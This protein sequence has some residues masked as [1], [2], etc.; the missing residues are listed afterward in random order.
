MLSVAAAEP[1]VMTGIPLLVTVANSSANETKTVAYRPGPL[2]FPPDMQGASVHALSLD[3]EV[4]DDACFS[5][6][7]D[8]PDL[9]DKIVLVRIS[10]QCTDMEQVA[11]IRPYQPL[12]ILFYH[13]PETMFFNPWSDSFAGP[14]G[15]II[16]EAG[17]YIV[18]A[19]TNGEI[20]TLDFSQ[21]DSKWV[22]MAYSGHAGTPSP[23][24]G[25]GA[26]WDLQIKP[27]IAAPGAYITAPFLTS[28]S[29]WR[30]MSGTFSSAPYVAGVAAL[31]ISK[32]G[33]RSQHGKGF[34]KMLHAR[35]TSSG[36]AMPWINTMTG[37]TGGS[38]LSSPM[39]V[40]TGLLDARKVMNYTTQLSLT[41]F[42]LNDTHHFSRYHSVD[43]TNN[44]DKEV[45]YTFAVQD[46]GGFDAFETDRSIIDKAP[47]MR[48]IDAI[49]MYKLKPEV[50]FPSG[51]FRVKAGETRKAE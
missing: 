24:T 21:V 33:G 10:L 32:H 18:N 46:A 20:V 5:L 36:S 2:A 19:I 9:T 41:R 30:A 13:N 12:G 23:F 34:A 51:T 49:S 47:T 3:P 6:P 8:T 16:P 31:Y 29:M 14:M 42:N 15:I 45:V 1:N 7:H 44:G 50:R 35:I 4:K 25:W 37:D 26:T 11:N 43:I 39:Q 17:R 28:K 40:G 48:S 22:E 27:D 38:H